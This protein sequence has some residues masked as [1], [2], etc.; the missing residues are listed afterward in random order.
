MD[1]DYPLAETLAARM[2]SEALARAKDEDGL[3]VR[4]IGK[5]MNYKTAVVLSH[6][7]TGRVPIPIDR[8]PELAEILK[9]DRD[10]FLSAVLQQRHP[11]IDWGRLFKRTTFSGEDGLAMELEAVLGSKLKDLTQ[12]QRAVM[13]EVAGER[14][15]R[16]RWLSVH[17]LGMVTMLRERFP[18]MTTDGLDQ[19]DMVKIMSAIE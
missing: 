5:L 3:S 19:A 10:R 4:Q 14:S 18:E 8:A 16:R 1:N 6:M 2:L 11:D 17:E 15:P 13:R 9:L 12:E 7:A